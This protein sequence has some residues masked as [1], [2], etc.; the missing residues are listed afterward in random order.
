VGGM[1]SGSLRMAQWISCSRMLLTR[2]RISELKRIANMAEAYDVAIAPHSPLGPIALAACLQVDLCI[3]NFVI[4]DISLGIHYNLE[5]GDMDLTSYLKDQIVFHI[6]DG[7]VDAPKGPGLGIEID[8]DLVM[9]ISR[10]TKPWQ[11]KGF[12][13]PDGSVREW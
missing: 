13:G 2:G 4:Q 3:P 12:H 7:Y 6:K 11:P 5:A 10:E 1:S 8:E 9:R